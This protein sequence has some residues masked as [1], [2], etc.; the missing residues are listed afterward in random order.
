M[1]NR[2][3][4]I[5][6]YWLD[7]F[8]EHKHDPVMRKLITAVLLDLRYIADSTADLYWELVEIGREKGI[9]I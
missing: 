7:K 2:L 9:G 3:K 5:Y 1:E 6:L 8:E 4:E